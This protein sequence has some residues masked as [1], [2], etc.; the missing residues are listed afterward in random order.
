[1]PD[2]SAKDPHSLAFDQK[3]TLWF[4]GGIMINSK[5][6]PFF[7]EFGANKVARSIPRRR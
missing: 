6:V 3:G 5:G 1:M 4:Y 7:V 2:P